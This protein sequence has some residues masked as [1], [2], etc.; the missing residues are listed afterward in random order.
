[1]IIKSVKALTA[2]AANALTEMI[3]HKGSPPLM[4]YWEM[5]LSKW[6]LHIMHVRKKQK[7]NDV[8]PNTVWSSGV[9]EPNLS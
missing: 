9:M 1:M 2:V 6:V 7:N 4:Q 3:K 8:E 5:F